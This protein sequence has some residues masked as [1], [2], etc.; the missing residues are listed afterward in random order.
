MPSWHRNAGDLRKLG[1]RGVGVPENLVV[2]GV[3]EACEL[4][5]HAHGSHQASV[6]RVTTKLGRGHGDLAGPINPPSF[7]GAKYGLLLTDEATS[8]RSYYA[9][10]SKAE[11]LVKFK[12]YVRDLR[13]LTGGEGK[14][15]RSAVTGG[16]SS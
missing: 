7:K 1:N 14:I 9:L 15:G 2:E 5:K 16:V 12:D 10:K 3:C 4:G 11:T 13:V 8:F 6:E